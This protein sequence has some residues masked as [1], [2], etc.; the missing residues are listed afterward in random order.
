MRCLIELNIVLKVGSD[1][2]LFLI[3]SYFF[4]CPEQDHRELL[5]RKLWQQNEREK[6]KIYEQEQKIKGECVYLG[7]VF[8]EDVFD[9]QWTEH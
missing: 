5:A 8:G 6:L 3:S 9:N 2:S 1:P 4:H 7:I